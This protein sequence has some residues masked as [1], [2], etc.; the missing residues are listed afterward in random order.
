MESAPLLPLGRILCL[1][2][3]L[4]GAPP[5]LVLAIPRNGSLKAA[6]EV[7]VLG[8][9]SKLGPELG[10]V[11]GITTVVAGTVTYPFEVILGLAHGTQDSTK[12]RDVILLPVR[13]DEVG[14]SDAAPGKN[15]PH[16]GTVIL[17]MNPV[18]NVFAVAIELGADAVNHIGNLT[19]NELLN[20]LVGPVVV[21]A[22]GNRSAQTISARPG[23]DEHVRR[24]LGGGIRR[25]RAIRS[26]LG[27]A[28]RVV[29]REVSIDLVRAHVVIAHTVLTAGLEQAIGALHVGAQERLRV[30]DGVVVVRLGSVVH[31]G[32]V[33]GDQ[34]IEQPSVAD[35]PHHELHAVLGQAGNVLGVAGVG[36]LVEHSHVHVRMVVDNMVDEVASDEAATAGDDDVLGLEDLR[37]VYHSSN[38][39]NSRP[40]SVEPAEQSSNRS[41]E[42]CTLRQFRRHSPD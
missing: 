12:H 16:G 2:G 32:V 34:A 33:A 6:F 18:A 19:W 13:A 23:A 27:E 24:S 15:G 4:G 10:G 5:G 14:L 36:E 9:P 21:G 40:Q 3:L 7:G 22:I 1:G 29:E 11:D 37:H 28:R 20:V 26:F 30:R 31:D 41:G 8:L 25:A 17:C 38:S 42:I 35:V 39:A